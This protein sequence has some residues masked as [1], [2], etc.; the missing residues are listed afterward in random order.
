MTRS[1]KRKKEKNVLFNDYK[2][3]IW[4]TVW[5]LASANEIDFPYEMHIV[6]LI[7]SERT[8]STW[9]RRNFCMIH[10]GLSGYK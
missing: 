9:Y 3:K 6:I 8:F 10:N 4:N 7:V 1:I 2:V 5:E